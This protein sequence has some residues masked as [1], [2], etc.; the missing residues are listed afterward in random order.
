V[1]NGTFYFAAVFLGGLLSFLSPCTV[2]LL[3]VY[4]GYLSRE[5]AG[6][7]SQPRKGLDFGLVARTLVFVLGLSSAFFLLGFG[8]G[9]LG[10]VLGGSA[11]RIA[12]G[13]VVILMGILMT[14]LLPIPF[15]SREWKAE[16]GRATAGGYVGAFVLGFTFSFGWTPCAGPVLA[17]VVGI[18]SQQGSALYGAFLLLVYAMGLALPFVLISFAST[19]FLRWFRRLTPHL[20][21]LRIV[22]GVLIVGMGVLLVLDRLTWLAALVS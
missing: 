1:E 22:G 16:S 8:A 6:R 21:W 2:P 11:F 19:L 4:F 13:V 17:T 20:G 12:M 10:S 3:P 18:A 14:G 9:A 7:A 15:L 5:A